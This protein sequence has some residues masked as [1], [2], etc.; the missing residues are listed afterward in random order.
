[1][2]I[3]VLENEPSRARGGQEVSL[4]DVCRGLARRGH[5]IDLSHTTPGDLLDEYRAFC[6][7]IEH[8]GA[9][10]IDRRRVLAAA[11]FVVDALRPRVAPDVVY[12]N[13]YLDS[14]FARAVAAR[15]GRPF[16]CHVRLPPPD[17]FC[18]Q[19]RWGLR[20]AVR[21]IA[22]SRR[23]RLDYVGR[24]LR[25]DRIAVVHNGIDASEWPFAEGG[26]EL[27][28]ELDVPQDAFVVTFA[29]RLHPIKGIE[30][31]IDALA[32]LPASVVL[33]IAGEGREDGSSRDYLGELRARADARGV[34]GRCRFIGHVRGLARLYAA[35]DVTVLPSVGSEAF[36][37]V[38]VESMA[39]GT[40]AVASR[41]GGIPEVLTGQF[42][43]FLFEA[44][45]PCALADRLQGL[46]GWRQ[47]DPNLARLCRDHVV[48]HFDLARTVD[49]VETVLTEVVDE[50]EAGRSVS[51]ATGAW[52]E[53][54]PR[55]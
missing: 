34:S 48:R 50:W 39:C 45:D 46:I 41:I 8:V 44:G 18:A 23:T 28:A 29:G 5:T 24:G 37:R 26:A 1:M 6:R 54:P 52:L 30:V 38:V 42:D 13:Q 12:A 3:L 7:R 49:G 47:R 20:G 35:S 53:P 17:R 15:L 10:T 51:A 31:L 55:L 4:F 25:H 2:R 27:R 9:Y 21:L 33:L 16:V 22:I 11:R 14:P 32:L 36:G 43:P 19:Y 40:P